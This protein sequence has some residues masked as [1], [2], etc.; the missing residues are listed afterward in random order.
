MKSIQESDLDWLLYTN[1]PFLPPITN[2]TINSI[3]EKIRVNKFP[4][5]FA[6]STEVAML[7]TFM[8]DIHIKD[9]EWLTFTFNLEEEDLGQYLYGFTAP[10]TLIMGSYLL[11]IKPFHEVIKLINPS[12]TKDET[13]ISLNGYKSNFL[14]QAHDILVSLSG[15]S[16]SQM[17]EPIYDLCV[18]N[19]FSNSLYFQAGAY[20]SW[21][22]LTA[23]TTQLHL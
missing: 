19:P 12:N 1:G 2:L 16:V 3:I 17:C 9:V 6:V 7:G 8:C 11:T 5:V 21:N 10:P 20:A 18:N 4:P 22:T 15:N 13:I 23:L 14:H